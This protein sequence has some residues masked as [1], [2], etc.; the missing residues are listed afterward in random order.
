MKFNVRRHIVA[1]IAIA[2]VSGCASGGSRGPSSSRFQEDMGRLLAGPLD[3]V[4]LEMFN[5]HSIPLRRSEVTARSILYESLWIPRDVTQGELLNGVIGARNRVI[6]RGR[7]IEQGLDP[8]AN[9]FRVT[10]VVENHV[11]T[12]TVAEWHPSTIPDP[13]RE[14]FADLLSDM[15]LELRTGIRR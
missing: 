7:L 13:A 5:R 4:R 14:R 12:E 8:G 15:N 3:D 11:R 2:A 1:F 9:V 6:I 10:F